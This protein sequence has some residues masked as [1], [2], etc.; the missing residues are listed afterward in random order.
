MNNFFSQKGGKYSLR[1]R[2]R[3]HLEQTSPQASRVHIFLKDE[4]KAWET[5]Q[6]SENFLEFVPCN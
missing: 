6:P 4:L 1:R 2:K 5:F 3:F